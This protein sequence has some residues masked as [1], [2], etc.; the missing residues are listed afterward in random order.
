MDVGPLKFWGGSSVK[1]IR[2]GKSEKGAA[3]ARFALLAVLILYADRLLV[4]LE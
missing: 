3:S 2:L 1:T 4:R